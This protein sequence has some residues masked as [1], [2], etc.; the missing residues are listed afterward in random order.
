MAFFSLSIALMRIFDTSF[1]FNN[2]FPFCHWIF[3]SFVYYVQKLQKK[4]NH[5]NMKVKF[6]KILSFNESSG[7]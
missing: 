2:F 1:S 6:I 4:G 7:E 3:Y 5:L